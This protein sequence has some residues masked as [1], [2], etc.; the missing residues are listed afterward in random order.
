MAPALNDAVQRVSGT[1][2][3]GPAGLTV[4]VQLV[5]AGHLAQ[6]HP[7]GD[8][9]LRCRQSPVGG[10]AVLEVAHEGDGDRSG[11]QGRI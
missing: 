10:L 8:Q 4:A 1:R 11:R 2:R 5:T 9:V 7:A 3:S 6:L